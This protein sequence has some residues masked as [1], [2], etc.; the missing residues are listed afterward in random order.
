MVEEAAAESMEFRAEV[1][2]LLRILSH[3][4]YK[5]RDIF[6]RELISNASD[7][8]HRVQFVMLTEQDVLD[9]D[10]EL[11]IH[12]TADEE[13]NTLT[14]SDTG[15]GMT[16]E[17]LI[18][19]LGTI[20]HS[21]AMAFLRTLEEGQKLDEI[22]G[23]FG[24]GF[25]AVF[26]VADEVRVI[27]RSYRPGAE[28][29]TWTSSGD[30][31]YRMG[32]AEKATRGTTIEIQLKEDAKEFV[33]AWRLEQIVQ[34]YSNYVSF[35][36]YVEDKVANKQT[37][38]WRQPANQVDDDAYDD[39][40]RQLTMDF[41]PPLLH[42][43]I[44]AD[45]PVEVRSILYVPRN[46]DAGVLRTRTDYGLKLFSRKVLI[47]DRNKELL[48]EYLRFVEG[49]VDSADIPLNVARET[50]QA[51]R[52]IGHIKRALRGRLIRAFVEMGEEDPERYET[53]WEAW[54]PFLKEG[55][56]TDY[57]GRDDLLPLLRFP[58]SSSEGGLRSLADYVK[59]M[60]ESQVDIYYI[61]GESVQSVSRSPHLD[62]FRENGWEVLYLV[63]PLDAFMVQSLREFEGKKLSNVDD[64]DLDLP[65][66]EPHADAD[67]EE[68]VPELGPEVFGRL[69]ARFRNILGERVA[70]VRES[71]VLKG[72]PCRLVSSESGPE[73]DMQR[74]RRLLEEDYEIP[75]KIL[76][77]NRNHPLIRNLA[78]LIGTPS[79]D[80]FVD[81]TI[82]QLFEN[83]LLLEGLH[84]NPVE[85]VSRIE[86]LLEQAVAA[87]VPPEAPA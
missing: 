55:V 26:M 68:K 12:I 44:S 9:S 1:Q 79:S 54:G 59:D 84:P 11:A 32:P 17:E 38:L 67:T 19:N 29:W 13:A 25:Y 47:Q 5:E 64:P 6:L 3:S 51:S 41:E 61:L 50:V 80:P 86:S 2:Q 23:Q 53:F 18:E 36:I 62:V 65:K 83:L 20:A 63:D 49:V 76:E 21:G 75:A 72:S 33:S 69:L 52:A 31:T 37:A 78:R 77:V 74:V 56:A 60:D 22:I 40:Y 35:P 70:E 39:F 16:R 43:H 45:V 30:S 34:A 28:A 7:A 66:A 27:S 73:R 71:K 42:L 58:T 82:E 14:I 87:S 4:L 8:L 48:P 46:R 10:A 15:I 81:L 57:A 85:M 24:V